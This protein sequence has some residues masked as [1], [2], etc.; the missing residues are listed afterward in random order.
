M[1]TNYHFGDKAG[2]D[3]IG[4]DKVIVRGRHNVGMNKNQES[5]D[6]QEALREL[7]N[8]VQILQGQ[9]SA[10]DRQVLDESINVIRKAG[11][12]EKG[13][14]R[15]ALGTIAGVATIVGQVGV[16]VIES[17]HALTTALGI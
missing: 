14:L 11:N 15:R 10:A 7:I 17:V 12:A 8:A 3:V 13:T 1:S 16:P 9:V 2:R 4:G 5:A 6:P